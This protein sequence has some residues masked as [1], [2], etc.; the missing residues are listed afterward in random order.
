VRLTPRAGRDRI[1]G[2]RDG[3]LL[4]RVAAPPVDGRAN[5]ALIRLLAERLPLPARAVTI[6]R[7]ERGREKLV[8]IE[9]LSRERALA[10]LLDA[11][12]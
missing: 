7:G 5:V 9:G 2:E 4:V 8:A 6:R 12:R 1:D 10:A 11:S 3:V